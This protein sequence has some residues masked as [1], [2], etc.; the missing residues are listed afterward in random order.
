MNN[1]IYS[2]KKSVNKKN[3]TYKIKK[4]IINKD[5]FKLFNNVKLNNDN[6]GETKD[7]LETQEYINKLKEN[8]NNMIFN[9]NNI[10]SFNKNN[11]EVKPTKNNYR[12]NQI[13]GNG[14]NILFS[15]DI[16]NLIINQLKQLL[17]NITNFKTFSIYNPSITLL[18]QLNTGTNES[19]FVSAYYACVTRVNCF[20]KNEN[21]ISSFI[22][23]DEINEIYKKYSHY[24]SFNEKFVN[25]NPDYYET[26]V[27]S[28]GNI[29]N[30]WYGP[31]G[32]WQ[33]SESL[34]SYELSILSIIRTNNDEFIFGP[35]QLISNDY[36][37]SPI[38]GRIINI[39]NPIIYNF[40]DKTF[41]I[42]S[43]YIVGNRNL[44]GKVSN[45]DIA[46]V[47][48]KSKIELKTPPNTTILNPANDNKYGIINNDYV[49]GISSVWD[50]QKINMFDVIPKNNIRKN[51]IYPDSKNPEYNG[52]L[53]LDNE[54]GEKDNKCGWKQ[55]LSR[56]QIIRSDDN[57]F[58]FSFP[59]QSDRCRNKTISEIFNCIEFCNQ[60]SLANC[61]SWDIKLEK[62]YIVHY[63]NTYNEK[64]IFCKEKCLILQYRMTESQGIIFYFKKF[65]S[66]VQINN[67]DEILNGKQVENN[68][69]TSWRMVIYPFNRES[70][71]FFRME[72]YF[73]NYTNFKISGTTPF[74]ELEN[75]L[76][77]VGHIK[78]N[79][80]EYMNY[81]IEEYVRTN[82]ENISYDKI[83]KEQMKE[84]FNY[85]TDNLFILG[86]NILELLNSLIN[87]IRS[88]EGKNGTLKNMCKINDYNDNFWK[89]NGKLP[90]YIYLPYIRQALIIFELILVN[91][92]SEP[93][94][95]IIYRNLH[96][97]F[98]YMM[99]FYKI[100][101]NDLT[102]EGFSDPFVITNGINTSFINFPMG[103]TTFQ[104]S[105]Y[106][107]IIEDKQFLLSY[108]DGDCNSKIISL[109]FEN[110]LE[111]LIHN[112][113]TEI[114]TINY[115]IID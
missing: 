24:V 34:I 2:K 28:P 90:S 43:F 87:G 103:L 50:Y 102:L 99:F 64:R 7:L 51:C 19:D 26:F 61:I 63:F 6:I 35:C 16:S 25:N 56:V 9:S 81:K 112:D 21:G 53:T 17:P 66:E 30:K 31:N 105:R 40:G 91:P 71:I 110:V 36:S 94:S 98:I 86:K 10:N 79:I 32:F 58:H 45:P 11:I 42:N 8:P 41:N 54:L 27:Q 70:N 48:L 96:P 115:K 13:G 83:T 29:F 60:E 75:S 37:S 78:V 97:T 52:V 5:F 23:D 57:N 76:I 68:L 111:S 4:G 65:D 47:K 80:F 100:N 44:N 107:G 72:T 20:L 62:N 82:L 101:K 88:P 18:E 92:T 109:S 85:Y 113:K 69:D 38:D 3:K 77:A 106:G 46:S 33:S 108:G 73:Q 114:D 1:I 59:H 12:N 39:N 93:N 95:I 74:L 84:I 22:S 89:N 55:T 14:V 104:K 49:K 15:L 67:L